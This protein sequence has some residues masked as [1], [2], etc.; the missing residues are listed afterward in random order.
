MLYTLVIVDI[1]DCVH[2]MK[3]ESE[4]AAKITLDAMKDGSMIEAI[5]LAHG[6]LC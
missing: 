5:F 2:S 1:N 3:F 4:Y 6:S